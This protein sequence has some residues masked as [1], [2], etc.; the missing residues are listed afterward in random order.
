VRVRPIWWLNDL[1]VRPD[2]RGKGAGRGLLEAAGDHARA[3]AAAGLMLE[4]GA[5]NQYAQDLYER[6]GYARVDPAS[7]FYW[8]DLQ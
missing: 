2:A 7:R 8:L 6:H 1:F 3:T 4:T 5:D